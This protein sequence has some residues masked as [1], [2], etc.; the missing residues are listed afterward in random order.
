MEKYWV[1]ALY[2]LLLRNEH[3][4]QIGCCP[5]FKLLIILGLVACKF[6]GRSLCSALVKTCLY[7]NFIVLLIGECV[8]HWAL[9]MVSQYAGVYHSKFISRLAKN[10]K[11]LLGAKS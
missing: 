6:N 10:E 3:F 8:H 9:L 11:W 1:L 7:A 5:D 4:H 2:E